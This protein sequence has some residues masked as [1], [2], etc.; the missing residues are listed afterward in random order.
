M[1]AHTEP[2][3]PTYRFTVDEVLRMVDAGLLS[4]AH[5]ELLEGELVRMT[6]KGPLHVYIAGAIHERLLRALPNGWTANKEDP[7]KAEATSAPEP[8]VSIIRGTRRELRGR[9][10]TGRDCVLAIEVAVS[11]LESDREKLPIYAR[12][13]V[14]EVWILDVERRRLERYAEP[15]EGEYV[16]QRVLLDG[17][18][19]DVPV[20]GERWT[21][22]S[23][24]D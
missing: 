21:V 23:L 11:T 16:S 24:F 12:G 15:R 18:E 8:D 2:R 6:A 1:T 13:S 20:I 4:D 9:L 14:A 3:R 10:P 7:V 17:E 5:V 22:A 19:I